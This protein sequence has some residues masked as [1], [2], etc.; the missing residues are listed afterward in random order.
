[1]VLVQYPDIY[2]FTPR[3][4]ARAIASYL[5]GN[6]LTGIGPG[7]EYHCLEHN[8]LGIALKEP[9]HNSLPLVSATIYC[10]VAQRFGLHAQPCGFPFH[11]HVIVRPP[12]GISM[13][14]KTLDET[15]GDPIYMDPFR[16]DRETPVADLQGQLNFLGASAVERSSLLGESLTSDIILRCSKNI[17][18]SVRRMSQ[19]PGS[20]NSVDAASATYAALWSSMLLSHSSQPAEL[21]HHLPWLMELFATEFPFDTFLIERFIAPLFHGMVEHEHI[22]K[23][24]HVMRAVDN[25]PRQAKRRASCTAIIKY[26]IGQVLRHR[27]YK[28]RAAIIG[29]DVETDNSEHLVDRLEG[30]RHHSFYHIL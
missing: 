11:V 18:N 12:D 3:D 9:G 5:R 26:R 2:Q 24:L 15:E 1:M 22:L 6:D 13:D 4:K 14:G 23:H 27:R 28:Y 30:G 7:R 19:R 29:W 16:S 25:L 8:F 21:R 10:Y 17:L 20:L